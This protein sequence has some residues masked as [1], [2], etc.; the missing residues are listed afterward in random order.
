MPQIY[1]WY[2]IYYI[3]YACYGMHYWYCK[4]YF[5]LVQTFILFSEVHNKPKGILMFTSKYTEL[6]IFVIKCLFIFCL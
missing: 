6:Y 1:N 3:P 2:S 5:F 4:I